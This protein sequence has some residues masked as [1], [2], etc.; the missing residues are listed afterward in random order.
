MLKFLSSL[1][2]FIFILACSSAPS[3][4]DPNVPTPD[5]PENGDERI[6]IIGD[7]GT[8]PKGYDDVYGQR[9]VSI[10]LLNEG[11]TRVLYTGDVIY[12]KG[13][14]NVE[15]D[16]FE[17]KFYSPYKELLDEQKV[18]FYMSMGNHDWYGANPV[19]I[20]QEKAKR[21]N[22]IIYDGLAFVKKFNNVCIMSI[23][24]DQNKH[25]KSQMDWMDKIKDS[26]W[27]NDC[28]FTIGFGHHPYYSAGSHGDG[29]NEEKAFLK[30]MVVG[31]MDL[32]VCGHDHDLTDEGDKDG[33]KLLVSGAAGKYRDLDGIPRGGWG[34][35]NKFGYLVV[36]YKKSSTFASYRFVIVN[37]YNTQDAHSGIIEIKGFRK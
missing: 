3:V 5:L 6:C 14:K 34:V 1:I 9:Y 21:H 36:D 17:E 16:Q 19:Y 11:C 35:G 24:T 15:D 26:D 30:Y 20:W 12:E 33:T 8:G 25:F 37:K 18:P 29:T 4:P 28:K 23:E 32:Y 22:Q 13:L 7:G 31:K 2:I 10:A 27:W